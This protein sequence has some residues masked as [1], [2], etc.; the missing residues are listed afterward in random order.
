MPRSP[1]TY[2]RLAGVLRMNGHSPMI[3]A[4]DNRIVSLVTSDDLRA[5]D[6]HAVIVEGTLAGASRLRL[7]WIGRP[8]P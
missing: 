3:E 8:T 1:G 6:G 2:R 4:D 7:E 5:F